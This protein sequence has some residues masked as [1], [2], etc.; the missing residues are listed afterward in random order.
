MGWLF[1]KWSAG[2]FADDSVLFC[3][4]TE[5]ECQKILEILANY[6]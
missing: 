2:I 3:R 4:V 5:A 6:E 1:K